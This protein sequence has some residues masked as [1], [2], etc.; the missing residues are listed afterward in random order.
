MCS[1]DCLLL[2]EEHADTAWKII[3]STPDDSC[4]LDSNFTSSSEELFFI[5]YL[6]TPLDGSGVADEFRTTPELFALAGDIILL[7]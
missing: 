2:P 1:L 5:F 6:C 3:R 7:D 4:Y